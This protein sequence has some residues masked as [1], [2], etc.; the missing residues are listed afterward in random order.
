MR[1]FLFFILFAFSVFSQEGENILQKA[2][3]NF[4]DKRFEE[5][6][7]LYQ[8]YLTFWPEAKD[9]PKAQFQNAES[10]FQLNRFKEAIP[11]FRKTADLYPTSDYASL[12]ILRIGDSYYRIGDNKNAIKAYE[13]VIKKTPETK[14]AEEALLYECTCYKYPCNSHPQGGKYHPCL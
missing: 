7:K 3:T 11:S 9:A 12:A 8:E 5:A 13:E 6:I 14:E 2:E 10:L 1:G 4:K